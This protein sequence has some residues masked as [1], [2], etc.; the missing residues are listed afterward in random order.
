MGL[1][2][3]SGMLKESLAE[4]H[5]NIDTIDEKNMKVYRS[6]IINESI[7]SMLNELKKLDEII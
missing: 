5:K 4:I 6:D 1:I 2:K 3:K 7:K